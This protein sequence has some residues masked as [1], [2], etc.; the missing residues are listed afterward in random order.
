M[1]RCGAKEEA[2]NFDWVLGL[3]HSHNKFYSRPKDRYDGA[4]KKSEG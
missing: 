3:N 4:S 1:E 2:N